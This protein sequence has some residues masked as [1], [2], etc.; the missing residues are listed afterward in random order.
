M[1]KGE[2]Q[3]FISDLPSF[4]SDKINY[5]NPGTLEEAIRIENH[6]YE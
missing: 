2:N 5:D 1:K 4:Y 3:I 6:L